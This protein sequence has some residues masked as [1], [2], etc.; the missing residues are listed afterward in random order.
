MTIYNLSRYKLIDNVT[1]KEI[2]PPSGFILDYAND[3]TSYFLLGVYS[4]KS[5]GGYMVKNGNFEIV[6]R[7]A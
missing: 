7:W 1:K 2:L 3:D 6:S 5:N 4:F